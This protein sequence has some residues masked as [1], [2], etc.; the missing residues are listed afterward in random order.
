MILR[1]EDCREFKRPRIRVA[2]RNFDP[3]TEMILFF[4]KDKLKVKSIWRPR[5][6]G[7]FRIRDGGN[8][9]KRKDWKYS[10]AF[11]GRLF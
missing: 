3:F 2:Q 9:S 8:E 11:Q 7:V 1:H 6:V 10:V 4:C 5:V